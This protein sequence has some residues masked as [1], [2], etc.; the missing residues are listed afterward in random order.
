[1][2]DKLMQLGELKLGGKEKIKAKVEKDVEDEGLSPMS[3]PDAYA[4]PGKDQ[5]LP[6]EEMHTHLQALR[7]EHDAF[8]KDLT[9]F[10]EAMASLQERGVNREFAAAMTTFFRSV[11]ENL[12]PHNRREEKQLFPLLA[13][14]LIEAGEHSKGPN[15]TTAVDVLE[16]DH[17]QMSQLSA[18][19]FNFF[20]LASRL[21]DPRSRMM[22]YDA[23]INQAKVFVE[24]VRLHI[25]R[26]DNVVFSLAQKYITD[27]EFDA[28]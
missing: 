28:L 25:F 20:G 15:P 2:A 18:I 13:R 22:V 6:Y 27:D 23:A 17:V 7:D 10:E 12:L 8:I 5:G 11:D 1:M 16:E 24:L 9:K 21:P 14:K 19:I 4:P 3:P 26:E